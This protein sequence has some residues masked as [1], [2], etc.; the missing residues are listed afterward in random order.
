[1]VSSKRRSAGL[2]ASALLIAL[3]GCGGGSG[4]PSAGSRLLA[5]DVTDVTA[6]VALPDGSVRV[7]L[8]ASGE[9]RDVSS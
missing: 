7:G 2:A 6:H 9:I 3:A 5:P 1:M 4:T 8:R